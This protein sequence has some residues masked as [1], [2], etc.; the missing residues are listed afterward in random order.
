M[1]K[2]EKKMPESGP[3]L[4]K[5]RG[6]GN[7]SGTPLGGENDN[8]ND[9]EDLGEAVQRVLETREIAGKIFGVPVEEIEVL[10]P[11]RHTVVRSPDG[12]FLKAYTHI[13]PLTNEQDNLTAFHDINNARRDMFGR[14]YK[15]ATK[16]EDKVEYIGLPF[17]SD[18]DIRTRLPEGTKLGM[19]I[20][21]FA[22]EPGELLYDRMLKRK[23]TFEDF[24]NA[25]IQI[26][27]IQQEGWIKKRA[28]GLENIAN[29]TGYFDER[30]RKVFL[31]QLIHF[32]EGKVDIPGE[33]REEMTGHWTSLVSQ[34]LVA[35]NPHYRGGFYYDGAPRHHIF[36]PDGNIVSLDFEYKLNVPAFLGLASLVSFGVAKNGK[37][38]LTE[39][40]AMRI[41]DRFALEMR[42]V[43]ALKEEKED[44]AY[45][46]LKY[47]HKRYQAGNHDLT[48]DTF[49][50]F[51]GEGDLGTGRARRDEYIRAFKFAQLE[52]QAMWIGHKARQ[53]K[54]GELL[55]KEK[56][57]YG[58]QDPSQF[59]RE[60]AQ[61]LRLALGIL[62]KLHTDPSS[63]GIKAAALS[64]YNR[65]TEYLANNPYFN[66]QTK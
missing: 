62:E 48:G 52:R 4:D 34:N 13:K 22:S 24:I 7:G 49:Y 11:S 41:I 61:H 33:I 27:R 51:L 21:I 3:T 17:L 30:F 45:D 29:D 16:S 55:A 15:A 20:S 8:F 65:F 28:L 59:G 18:L 26:A 31:G 25:A 57:S 39:E 12:K 47:V 42:N 46:M 66:P 56:I 23:A 37:S 40:E 5:R 44:L 38:Y 2:T 35:K 53:R 36:G 10:P 50:R 9:A 64:L 32:S 1:I 60:Q 14:V 6:R 19:N 54:L 63:N 43:E 58:I